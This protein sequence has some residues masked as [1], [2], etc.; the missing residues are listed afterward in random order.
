MLDYN[1]REKGSPLTMLTGTELIALATKSLLSGAFSQISKRGLEGIVEWMEA[2][3]GSPFS[4]EERSLAQRLLVG[5]DSLVQI[6][7]A[8]FKFSL[9]R[10]VA[11]VGPSGSGKTSL[12][13]YLRGESVIRPSA[14]T[15]DR[16]HESA[17]LGSRIIRIT[18]TPG[19]PI[20]VD[21]RSET[22]KYVERGHINVLVVMLCYGCLDTV[23]VAGLRRPGRREHFESIEKYVEASQQEEL[24]WLS[25]LG[26]HLS[27]VKKKIPYC[28]IVIN[29]MDQWSE[30]HDQ[31]LSYYSGS[32]PLRDR[33]DAIVRAACRSEV[34]ASFH[35]VACTYNSFKGNAPTG[36]MSAESCL[37]SLNILKEEIR[38]RLQEVTS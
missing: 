2:Q 1:R 16:K 30:R 26:D 11:I 17:R 7:K 28:M 29:K 36:T 20:H 37:L 13:N 15:A 33:I 32:G 31:V 35:P 5:E 25:D 19:S 27:Q 34:K 4:E 12:F 8:Q 10:G 38:L 23:G 9:R 14:S 6:L 22:F 24:D 21:L 18:D 3:K